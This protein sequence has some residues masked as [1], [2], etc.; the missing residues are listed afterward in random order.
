MAGE[1]T[2]RGFLRAAAGAAIAGPAS[3]RSARA[4]GTDGHRPSGPVVISSGNGLRATARAAELISQ[5]ASPVDAVVGGVAIVEADP[6]DHSVGLGGLPNERGIVELDASVMDGPTH[7]S[8]AVAALQRIRH[9]AQVALRVMRRSDHALLVGSGALEFARAHGFK[10]EDL[11]TEEAREIWLHWKEE[12]SDNDDWLPLPVPPTGEKADGRRAG[13]MRTYGTINCNAI[14]MRGNLGGVTSTSGLAFKM[15]GRVG[16]SPIIGAGLYV[17]NAVGAAGSTGRGEAVIKNCG[18]FAAVELM[19]Q[20][21]S[22]TDACLAVL[23]RMVDHASDPRL[24]RPDGRPRF[25]VKMYALAK[26]GAYGAASI[27]SGGRF[28]VYSAGRNRLEDAAY[29]FE[30]PPEELD[31]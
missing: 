14:D 22:P 24:L 9:P 6:S 15:P 29:L 7:D 28:A 1:V 2:R 8:G 26:S 31:D 12:L 10:E 11:L 19:R 20:G 23:H 21:A 16:D 4:L 3:A 5:G 27:W 25:D 13:A 17:D 30:R 18:A